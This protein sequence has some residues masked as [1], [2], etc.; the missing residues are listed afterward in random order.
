MQWFSFFLVTLYSSF[1]YSDWFWKYTYENWIYQSHKGYLGTWR[2][3]NIHKT[4]RRTSGD[5]HLTCTQYFL[6]TNIF[7]LWHAHVRVRIIGGQKCQFFWTSFSVL[8]KDMVS[9]IYIFYSNIYNPLGSLR[10]FYLVSWIF[11]KFSIRIFYHEN[12]N[13]VL[14]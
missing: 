7:T 14:K 4:F 8:T 10:K 1:F 3:L 13:Q 12:K 9:F 5:M 11:S 6:K 2:K